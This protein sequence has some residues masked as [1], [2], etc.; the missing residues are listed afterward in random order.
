[1]SSEHSCASDSK[2][3]GVKRRKIQ[4]QVE[5]HIVLGEMLKLYMQAVA[6]YLDIDLTRDIKCVA[7]RVEKEG[8]GFLAKTLPRYL[9]WLRLCWEKEQYTPCPGFKTVKAKRWTKPYP[10]F[11]SGLV[12]FVANDDGSL[13]FHADPGLRERQGFACRAISQICQSFGKKYEFPLEDDVLERQKIETLRSDHEDVFGIDDLIDFLDGPDAVVL[14][15]VREDLSEVFAPYKH[16]G[17]YTDEDGGLAWGEHEHVFDALATVPRHGAG[18]VSYP[19]EPHE[20]YTNF[21]GFPPDFNALGEFED[22]LY[23]PGEATAFGPPF[24]PNRKEKRDLLIG[25]VGR[26]ELVPKD[27]TKGRGIIL[28]M[29]EFMFPQQ[30]LREAMYAWLESCPRTRGHVNFTDQTINQRHALKSSKTGL[31]ATADLVR[32]SDSVT[33]VHIDNSFDV[34]MLEVLNPLRSRYTRAT[35]SNASNLAYNGERSSGRNAAVELDELLHGLDSTYPSSAF[36]TTDCISHSRSEGVVKERDE[37]VLF[38]ENKKYA[39]MGSALCFPVEALFFWAVT[40]AVIRHACDNDSSLDRADMQAVW[41]YGDDLVFPVRYF[42]RVAEVFGSLLVKF[43]MRKSFSKGPF[44]ESCGVDAY[45]GI[46]IT[47]SCRIS[48]RLPFRSLHSTDSDHARSLVAWIEY[49]NL[50]EA[51]GFPS[52]SRYIRRTVCVQYPSAKSIPRLTTEYNVGGLFWL[53]YDGWTVSDYLKRMRNEQDRRRYFSCTRSTLDSSFDPLKDDVKPILVHPPFYQ[54]KVNRTWAQSIS[55]YRADISENER[56]L[57]YY[58]EGSENTLA[59][60]WFP[61][62]SSFVLRRKT[63]FF[64]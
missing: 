18:A 32:A 14:D 28:E 56:R 20:K 64:S 53:D 25:G 60:Y 41:I 40:R 15:Y 57:R 11:L 39:P 5:E 49:A 13:I 45:D 63:A 35:I 38:A 48:T 23:L 46:D 1:M 2:S 8:L 36:K 4:G 58:S 54:G 26:L 61:D 30:M 47:P 43:N 51:D 17:V 21:M 34:G 3:V 55:H 37:T 62:K 42:D 50:F 31:M 10:S 12:E 33:R 44:R 16:V 6:T 24:I 19:C 9:E 29:K 22:C 7:A 27:A 59:G 52:V